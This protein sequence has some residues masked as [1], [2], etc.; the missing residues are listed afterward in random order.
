MVPWQG[1]PELEISKNYDAA[2]QV[3]TLRVKQLQDLSQCPLYKLPI[4]IDIYSGGKKERKRVVIEDVDQSF[5][6]NCPVNPDLVNFDAERQL[7]CVKTY[8]KG[9]DELIF[10]LK[11]APLFSDRFEAI[12]NLSA[13]VEKNDVLQL[14]LKSAET[15][16]WFELRNTAMNAFENI[17]TSHKDEIRPVMLRVASNDKNTNVRA[18]QYGFYLRITW[19]PI[20]KT[21]TRPGSTFHRTQ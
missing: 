13:S 8:S 21:H 5:N 17:A 3:L 14:L 16:P 15:D 6:F 19:V 20:W 12:S 4:D 10:Q 18:R 1:H 7:L 9:T 11:N 2:K